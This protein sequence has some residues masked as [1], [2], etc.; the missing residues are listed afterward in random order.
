MNDK[1]KLSTTKYAKSHVL[2]THFSNSRR[3][4]RYTYRLARLSASSGPD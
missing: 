4:Q 3:N 1:Y 2:T